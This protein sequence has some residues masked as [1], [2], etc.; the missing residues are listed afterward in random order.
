MAVSVI[1]ESRKA[2]KRVHEGSILWTV[3]HIKES[4]R[5]FVY[6]NG[7]GAAHATHFAADLRKIA[8]VKA[9]SFDSIPELTARTNDDGW[10]M[11][12]YDW[13]DFYNCSQY[14]VQ[15]IFSVG[16]GLDGLSKNLPKA[17]H[18]IV[19]ENGAFANRIVIPSSST[20]VIEGCQSVIAHDIVERLIQ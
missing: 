11:A 4:A 3:K 7:G 13:L 16:G 14:D 6:G 2:L 20:P 10:G 19:G 17:T 1:A 18:G 8:G 5:V 15:F 12:W 9:Y